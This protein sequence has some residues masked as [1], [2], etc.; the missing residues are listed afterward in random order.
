MSEKKEVLVIKAVVVRAYTGNT[1]FDEESCNRLTIKSDNMP[2]GDIWAYDDCGS[3]YTPKWLK[4][5][6]GY[7][8]LK[9]TFDI[10]VRDTRGHKIS[11]DDWLETEM[12]TG[13]EVRVKIKQKEGAVYPVAVVVL[14][15]GENV[16][17]FED[18]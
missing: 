5:A 7:M 8:N 2:Y 18:M 4:D 14:K 3:R 1:R 17:P 10:P 15:D 16:D 13:A 11:F 12:C 9:S 6:A